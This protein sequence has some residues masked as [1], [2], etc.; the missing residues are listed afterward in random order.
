ME[1]TKAMGARATA[2]GRE[3]PPVDAERRSWKA[4]RWGVSSRRRCG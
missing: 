1:E 3:R 4:V 2:S